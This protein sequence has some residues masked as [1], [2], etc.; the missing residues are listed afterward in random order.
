MK[1]DKSNEEVKEKGPWSIRESGV[2]LGNGQR[3]IS[4][5]GQ[6][7]FHYPLYPDRRLV[8]VCICPCPRRYM[9]ERAASNECACCKRLRG[10][11]TNTLMYGQVANQLHYLTH[12][13]FFLLSAVLSELELKEKRLIRQPVWEADTT[14]KRALNGCL[15]DVHKII[16]ITLFIHPSDSITSLEPSHFHHTLHI[17]FWTPFLFCVLV[18]CSGAQEHLRVFWC[19]L[20]FEVTS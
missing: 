16:T 15:S 8:A 18:V 13:L 7:Q 12:Q 6:K 11:L 1:N 17:E 14:L 19:R 9:H 5:Q 4:G 10:G 3:M 2:H 20:S